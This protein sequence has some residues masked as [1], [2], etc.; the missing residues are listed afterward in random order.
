MDRDIKKVISKLFSILIIFLLVRF[1]PFLTEPSS[2]YYL[3]DIFYF[4]YIN[5]LNL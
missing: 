5:I 3:C 4:L 2:C 1:M